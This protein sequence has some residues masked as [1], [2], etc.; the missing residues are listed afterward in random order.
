MGNSLKSAEQEMQ[1]KESELKKLQARDKELVN[2]LNPRRK[3]YD[4]C[5]FAF[6]ATNDCLKHVYF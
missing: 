2:E 5:K 1:F 3:F 4:N 6:F